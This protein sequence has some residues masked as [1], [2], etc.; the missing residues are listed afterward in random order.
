MP[1]HEPSPVEVSERLQLRLRRWQAVRTWAR[2]IRE[3]E[4][5]WRVDVRALHRLAAQELG[6]LVQEV[7]P[8]LRRRV[9]R[10]LARLG[11]ATRLG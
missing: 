1:R 9:N 11:V 5:L 2:L 8:Q 10:W 3:A 7:P 4:A 6:Q